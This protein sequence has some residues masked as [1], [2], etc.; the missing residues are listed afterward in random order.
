MIIL[1]LTV[2]VPDQ[3]ADDWDWTLD[4]IAD[5]VAP[6]VREQVIATL[7]DYRAETALKGLPQIE[8]PPF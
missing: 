7:I 1:R 2:P 3:V 4:D 6:L 5:H 8:R